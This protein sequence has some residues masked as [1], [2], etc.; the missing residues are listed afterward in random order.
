MSEFENRPRILVQSKEKRDTRDR[1]KKKLSDEADSAED[2]N[3]NNRKT[4]CR[5]TK[6]IHRGPSKPAEQG[7][8]EGMQGSNE[9]GCTRTRILKRLSAEAAVRGSPSKDGQQRRRGVWERASSQEMTQ[10][11]R[12]EKVIAESRQG[13]HNRDDRTTT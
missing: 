2:S 6:H 11:G 8:F 4:V 3:E 5:V 7:P 12:D 9:Y 1:R 10:T 13:S